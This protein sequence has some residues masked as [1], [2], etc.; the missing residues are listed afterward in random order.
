LADVARSFD[1][2]QIDAAL[3]AGGATST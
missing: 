2:A 1:R 3:T